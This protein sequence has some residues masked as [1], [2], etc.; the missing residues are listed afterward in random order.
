MKH[1][2]AIVDGK[3]TEVAYGRG[4]PGVQYVWEDSLEL[5]A[6]IVVGEGTESQR[7]GMLFIHDARA[8]MTSADMD[9]LHARHNNLPMVAHKLASHRGDFSPT[10]LIVLRP[11]QGER[12]R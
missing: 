8:K 3:I 7:R 12:E 5:A 9:W 1:Y 4:L 6:E 11:A 10:N 2:I